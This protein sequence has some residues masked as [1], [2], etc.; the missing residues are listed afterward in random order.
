M[1]CEEGASCFE[2]VVCIFH[3]FITFCFSWWL[4]IWEVHCFRFLSLC[5][6]FLAHFYACYLFRVFVLHLIIWTILPIEDVHQSFTH[7]HFTS[8]VEPP[9]NKPLVRRSKVRL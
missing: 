1:G 6:R 2:Q 7:E 9:F 8:Y 3:Y 4:V 5:P